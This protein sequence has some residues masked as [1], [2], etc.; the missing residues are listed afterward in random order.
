MNEYLKCVL[1]TRFP[2]DTDLHLIMKNQMMPIFNYFKHEARQSIDQVVSLLVETYFEVTPD[3]SSKFFLLNYCIFLNVQQI[4]KT[5]SKDLRN[6]YIFTPKML[7]KLIECLKYYPVDYFQQ[8]IHN[9][10]IGIFRNRLVSDEHK[11]E[12][13]QILNSKSN[14][15]FDIEKTKHF[16]VPNGAQSFNLNYMPE[17]EWSDIVKRNITICSK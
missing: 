16:F 12:F 11:M 7:S 10:A 8:A 14:R 1:F 15:L 3:A 17:N 13:D 5:F 6:H 4:K 9:E 2:D